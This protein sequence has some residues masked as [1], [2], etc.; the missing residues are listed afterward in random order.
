MRVIRWYL[1]LRVS[2]DILF[3]PKDTLVAPR[4]F[5]E[6]SL[7]FVSIFR[8]IKFLFKFKS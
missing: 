8:S 7:G 3:L 5:Q 1:I 4:Q 2:V 6:M